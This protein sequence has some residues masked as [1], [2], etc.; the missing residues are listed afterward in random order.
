M[1]FC[2]A[3]FFQMVSHQGLVGSSEGVGISSVTWA[4]SGE[5]DRGSSRRCPSENPT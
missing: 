5:A 4:S 3:F 1:L 2:R